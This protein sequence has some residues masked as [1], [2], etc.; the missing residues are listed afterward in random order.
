MVRQ[1]CQAEE[2]GQYRKQEAAPQRF[3]GDASRGSFE[4]CPEGYSS[5]HR[6]RKHE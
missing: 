5:G 3:R 4:R 6:E 1:Q 2:Y